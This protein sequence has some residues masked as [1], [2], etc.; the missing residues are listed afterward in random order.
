VCVSP[1]AFNHPVGHE[2]RLRTGVSKGEEYDDTWIVML[3]THAYSMVEPQVPDDRMP[4]IAWSA[5]NPSCTYGDANKVRKNDLINGA[6]NQFNNVFRW[7]EHLEQH[8]KGGQN[9]SGKLTSFALSE[10]KQTRNVLRKLLPAEMTLADSQAALKQLRDANALDSLLASRGASQKAAFGDRNDK[11]KTADELCGNDLRKCL[12]AEMLLRDTPLHGAL[13]GEADRIALPG[14]AFGAGFFAD[15]RAF[16]DD[17]RERERPPPSDAAVQPL[18]E[19]WFA[20]VWFAREAAQQ[21]AAQQA[22]AQAEAG[23]QH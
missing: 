11:R 19:A 21:A 10:C 22:A 8:P 23:E 18:Y 5:I 9:S 15:V 7:I 14:A 12:L 16:L 1:L 20:R 4:G 3:V 13:T 2:L 17:Y 6:R